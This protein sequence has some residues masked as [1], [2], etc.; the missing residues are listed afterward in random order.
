M[1]DVLVVGGGQGGLAAAHHLARTGTDFLVLD[2]ETG[3]G[4][5]WRHR[6]PTL[7][8]ATVNGIRELP[9]LPVPPGPPERP[10]REAVPEYFAEYERRFDLRVRRPVQVRDVRSVDRLLRARTTDGAEFT[11]RTLINATGTWTRPFWPTVPGRQVFAGRQL[12]THDYRGPG[13]FT[14]R[15]VVVVGGGISAVQLILEIEPVAAAVTWVTRREPVWVDREFT[16]ELGRAAVAMV[17]ERV[18]RGLPPRSVVSV[19][20]LPLTPATRGARESGV[21][22]RQPMFAELVPHGVRW[23]DGREE[24]A[25]VVL[26]CTGFRPALA[27]LAPLRLRS[28]AGGVQLVGTRAARDARVHLIG[29]GPSA[30]TVGASRAGRAAVT[31]LRA[32]LAAGSPAGPDGADTGAR[33]GRR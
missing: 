6:W 21:L 28:P 17:T 12:H 10:A 31:E 14:G 25:D 29:Y 22:R 5:A 32:L 11:A 30:S 9:G 33:G 16:T 18:E 26:W 2:A 27:H 4:G 20:G 3:P 24:Q 15:R 13:P 1:V 23:A 7:T 19:T 8:M